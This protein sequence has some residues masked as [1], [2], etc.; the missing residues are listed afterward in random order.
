MLYEFFTPEC[1]PVSPWI[2]RLYFPNNGH[3]DYFQYLKY[4]KVYC[5]DYPGNCLLVDIDDFSLG[6]PPQDGM[7]SRT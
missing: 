7:L 6:Y 5:N 1:C 2:L 3:L 4:H